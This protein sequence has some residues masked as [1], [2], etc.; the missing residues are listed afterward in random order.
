MLYRLRLPRKGHSAA[1]QYLA[2][3]GS[4]VVVF[5]WGHAQRFGETKLSFA[6]YDVQK[7]AYYEDA[8]SGV[9]YSGAYLK[10][11]VLAVSLVGDFDSHMAHLVKISARK[12]V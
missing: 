12:G 4:E 8:E 3:D 5:V 6:L 11:H 7:D 10:H 1:A 9:K 2:Q